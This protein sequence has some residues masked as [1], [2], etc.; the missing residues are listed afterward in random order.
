MLR[1]Q[2]DEHRVLEETEDLACDAP[3]WLAPGASHPITPLERPMSPTRAG[4]DP[5]RSPDS[6]PSGWRRR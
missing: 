6:L 3:R 4:E 2:Y 1:D 5:G